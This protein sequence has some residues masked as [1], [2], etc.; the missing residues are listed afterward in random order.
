[1]DQAPK[2]SQP[3]AGY[4]D[5][6][7]KYTP[8]GEVKS[9]TRTQLSSMI[10]GRMTVSNTAEWD[11]DMHPRVDRLAVGETTVLEGGAYEYMKVTKTSS[12]AFDVEYGSYDYV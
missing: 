11:E 4:E 5:D 6:G 2:P 12:N 9:L 10:H 8:E 1:M 3:L 7:M